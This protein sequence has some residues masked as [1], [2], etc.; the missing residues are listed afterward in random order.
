MD[1]SVASS[2]GVIGHLKLC[3]GRAWNR[4][5]GVFKCMGSKELKVRVWSVYVCVF[6]C[7]YKGLNA[8][9]ASL[10]GVNGHLK[11]CRVKQDMVP[12]KKS[13]IW[14]ESEK[15]GEYEIFCAEY[16]GLRHSYMMSAVKVIPGGVF[17][18]WTEEKMKKM[19]VEDEEDAS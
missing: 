11:L 8:T 1:S 16:C 15:V 14:F 3:R 18:K 7:I 10:V 6:R 12:G 9:V 19:R 17:D 5:G 2:I 4:A 13:F